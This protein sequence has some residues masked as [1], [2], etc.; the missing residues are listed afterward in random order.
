MRI[1]KVKWKDHPILGSL[2]LDFTNSNTGLPFD[3]IIFAGENGTGKTTI[4]E[5]ISTFLNVGSFK[6]FDKI[7]Y[8][9]DGTVYTATQLRSP[10]HDGFY[11]RTDDSGNIK[12][13]HTDKNNNFAS[14]SKDLLNIRHYGC[15]FSKAR[16]DYKTE[17]IK[18][19][20]TKK[21]DQSKYDNDQTENFT[22][23]KQ[24][25]VDIEHQDNAEYAEINKKGKYLSWNEFYPTSRIYRFKYR[26]V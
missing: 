3:N 14:I 17:S 18:S 26:K 22:S 25:I 16:A 1:K 20:T 23:S 5:S 21:L 6:Y 9:I 10:F 8:V 12:E 2:E 4:L 11:T 19:T 13:I 7:E 24:L 15:I